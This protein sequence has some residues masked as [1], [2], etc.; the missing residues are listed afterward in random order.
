MLLIWGIFNLLKITQNYCLIICVYFKKSRVKFT[1]N[2]EFFKSLL[3]KGF[4]LSRENNVQKII[5]VF[6]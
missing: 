1:K 2:Y 3:F 5:C 4:L 6:V